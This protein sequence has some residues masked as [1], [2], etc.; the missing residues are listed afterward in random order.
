MLKDNNIETRD[1]YPPLSK[2][3]YLKHS[4][5]TTLENSENTVDK[6]LWLPSSVSLTNDDLNHIVE[7]INAYDG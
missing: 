4:D 6:A 1:L 5:Q 7:I 3:R 2:Q